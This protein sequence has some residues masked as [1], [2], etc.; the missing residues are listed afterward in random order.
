MLVDIRRS[1]L[2]GSRSNLHCTRALSASSPFS[3]LLIKYCRNIAKYREIRPAR[4]FNIRDSVLGF[5]HSAPA[6]A[7]VVNTAIPLFCC[8]QMCPNIEGDNQR[9]PPHPN[10]E[11][12][13]NLMP[14]LK[15][16]ASRAG[17]SRGKSRC[18]AMIGSQGSSQPSRQRIPAGVHRK[19][20]RHMTQR[21]TP[22]PHQTGLSFACLY[23]S[24]VSLALYPLASF[25]CACLINRMLN[26]WEILAAWDRVHPPGSS[27]M[28][29]LRTRHDS[30]T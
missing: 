2:R 8:R 22:Q 27:R 1:V 18:A 30:T 13:C 20:F 29:L 6:V 4:S 23:P 5:F 10:P 11:W 16:V 9:S 12:G 24:S 26:E 28:I 3:S 19:Y 25:L 17:T 21:P 14:A 15:R 7:N